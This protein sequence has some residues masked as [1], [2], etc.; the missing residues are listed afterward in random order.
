MTSI[1][2]LVETIQCKKFRRFYRKKRKKFFIFWGIFKIYIKLSAF[3]K[4]DDPHPSCISG[5]TDPEKLGYKN[6]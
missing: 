5:I 1:L 6:F 4:K 2:L 3:P